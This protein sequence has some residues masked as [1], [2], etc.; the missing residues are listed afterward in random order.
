MRADRTFSQ[1]ARAMEFTIEQLYKEADYLAERIKDEKN[2][3]ASRDSIRFEM[4]THFIRLYE[5][6]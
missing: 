5:E 2:G 1:E 4:I 3:N 6:Y